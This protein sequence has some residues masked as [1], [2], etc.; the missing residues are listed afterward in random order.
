MLQALEAPVLDRL[1]RP[2]H[3]HGTL[4]SDPAIF[5]EELEKIWYRTWIYVGHESEVPKPG[6]FVMKS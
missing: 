5:A 4:Y 1:I 2:D 3:V 6:D